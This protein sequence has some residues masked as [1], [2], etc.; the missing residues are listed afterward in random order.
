MID[1]LCFGV[2]VVLTIVSSFVDVPI[3]VNI[4]CFSLAII[5]SS[6][7]KSVEQMMIE[8]KKI[9]VDKKESEEG[10]GVETMTKDDV[11]NFPLQAGGMLVGMYALIKYVGK[12]FVN[13]MILAYLGFCGGEAVKPLL[14]MVTGGA[15]DKLD[16]KKLFH[17]KLTMLEI[18]QDVTV[19]DIVCWIISF[20]MVG[21]YYVSKNWIYNNV[22]AIGITYSGIQQLFL[23][24]F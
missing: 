9:Y 17:M 22:L 20:A 3:Q 24:N 6:A 7:Y 5:I 19:C 11:Q 8:F 12:E 21:I 4:T 10:E 1:I 2:I 15:S 14:S 23:G 18:D 13:P 16:K